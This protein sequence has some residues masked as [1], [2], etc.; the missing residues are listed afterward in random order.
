MN[1]ILGVIIL[2]LFV[3]IYIQHSLKVQSN[4][5][6]EYISQKLEQIIKNNSTERLMLFTN[7]KELKRIIV[8]INELLDYNHK[9][10]IKYNRAEIS[11]RK[12]LSNISHDLKTPLTVVLGYVETLKLKTSLSNEEKLIMKIMTNLIKPT[13]GEIE[14]FGEKLTNTSYKF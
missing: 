8:D 9:N 13:V 2:I 5:D 11:M 10:M 4:K 1:I 14:I 7:N 6:I 12:M 3:I